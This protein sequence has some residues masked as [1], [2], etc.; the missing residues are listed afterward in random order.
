MRNLYFGLLTDFVDA[1]V[2]TLPEDESLVALARQGIEMLNQKYAGADRATS[3]TKLPTGSSCFT[4]HAAGTP[5]SA[6]GWASS[7]S[8][9]SS[10]T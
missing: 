6:G 2:E 5:R 10:R 7:A 8:A 3:A 1:P 9:E 4:V